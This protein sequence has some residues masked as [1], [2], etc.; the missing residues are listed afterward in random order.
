MIDNKFSSEAFSEAGLGTPMARQLAKE[1]QTAIL[2]E[3]DPSL[4]A[5]MNSVIEKL[6]KLGHKL[7][8]YGP[9]HA[10]EKHFREKYDGD[11]Q[12]YKF[13]VAIDMVVSVGY[14]ETTDESVAG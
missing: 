4:T 3:L 10:D 12:P 8:P 9:Q 14:P 7:K 13:L 1:L 5:A 11:A 2:E 6:N